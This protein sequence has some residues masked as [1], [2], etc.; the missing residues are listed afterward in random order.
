M[1]GGSRT[2]ENALGLGE[3]LRET[4]GN[5]QLYKMLEMIEA[6]LE[7][8]G[9]FS[10]DN[11]QS[12]FVWHSPGMKRLLETPGVIS[13]DF[14]MCCYGLKPPDAHLLDVDTRVRKIT[15]LVTNVIGLAKLAKRC[16]KK[17]EHVVALG[18]AKD[19][20]CAIVQRSAAAGVYPKELRRRWSGLIKADLTNGAATR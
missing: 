8:G 9:N 5:D 16:D 3:L 4:E 14:D 7:V 10:I 1:N 6:S 20:T 13:V 2:K 18:R 15:R 11:P 12:S 17:H 19:A